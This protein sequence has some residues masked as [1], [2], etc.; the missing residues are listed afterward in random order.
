VGEG[1]RPLDC[2][3]LN[4]PALATTDSNLGMPSLSSRVGRD[5]SGA[6]RNLESVWNSSNGPSV[7]ATCQHCR[8][9]AVWLQTRNGGWVLF[10]ASE[11]ATGDA[12]DGN[13]YAIDRRTRLVVDL[14]SVRESRWP[15]KCLTL[16][17]FRCPES[18]DEAR[19][20]RRRPRQPNDIDLSDLFRRLA[21]AEERKHQR[22][23]GVVDTWPA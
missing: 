15:A 11:R 18:Y 10:D 13:R 12:V 22:I 14:D 1:A 6:V 8:A 7:V 21:A 20:H 17:R 5:L 9:E 4:R 2:G 16:H 3:R 23:E 19:F